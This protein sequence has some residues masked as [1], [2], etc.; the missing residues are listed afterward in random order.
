MPS[1]WAVLWMGLVNKEKPPMSPLPIYAAQ[2]GPIRALSCL[3]RRSLIVAAMLAQAASAQKRIT[4]GYLFNSDP[5]C[6]QIGDTFYLFTTQDPFTVEFQRDNSFFK[7]MYAYHAFTTTD[8]DHWVDHGSILTG[9]DVTWNA[10]QALWDGDAG[11]PA[12]GQF[13]AYAPFRLN[14]TSEANYGRL[15]Y[16][17]L[18][19][20]KCHGAIQ[21]RLLR[22][23]NEE[24][25]WLSSRRFEPSG[26][27]WR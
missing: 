11:I 21:G 22:R 23:A 15:R 12:N 2:R 13:Y 8:F 17:R 5:T 10:G 25:G 9:R 20:F 26:R 4:P 24:C 27:Y 6:R 18:H 19:L 14:S 1:L 7:G 3:L 16:W